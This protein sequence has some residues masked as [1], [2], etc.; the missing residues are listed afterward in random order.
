MSTVTLNDWGKSNWT[1]YVDYWRDNDA[2]YLQARTILRYHNPTDRDA[3]N[4]TPLSGQVVYNEADDL[5]YYRSKDN[6]WKRYGPMPFNMA[7][8]VDAT[9]GV[10]LKHAAAPGGVLFT[11]PT[12]TPASVV[13]AQVP[14]HSTGSA[15]ILDGTGITLKIGAKTVKLDTDATSLHSD[16]PISASGF[17]GGT[18]TGSSLSVSTATVSGLLTAQ[19]NVAVTG[20]VSAAIGSN[21]GGVLFADQSINAAKGVQ[22][23]GGILVGTVSSIKISA[24]T[25]AAPGASY[26]EV[27]ATDILLHATGTTPIGNINLDGQPFITAKAINYR[28]TAGTVTKPIA[29]SFY[30]AGSP[31]V[32]DYPDGTIWIS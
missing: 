10:G 3:D 15:V 8:S 17:V 7:P 18:L 32:A 22:S 30:D 5:L 28:N 11:S 24:G 19:G 29:P 23:A 21:I 26:E 1:N 9:T 25:L 16:S 27:T 14:L 20:T 6:T 31:N 2:E 4:P 12:G 13:L